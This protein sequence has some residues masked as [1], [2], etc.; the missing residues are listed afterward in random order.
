MYIH[1]I[2]FFTGN[3]IPLKYGFGVRHMQALLIFGCLT[4]NLIARAHLSVTIVAMTDI[5]I[6]NNVTVFNNSDIDVNNTAHEPRN[7]IYTYTNDSVRQ[8]VTIDITN[9]TTDAREEI[10]LEIKVNGTEI[11]S[12]KFN[13]NENKSSSANIDEF[14]QELANNTKSSDS[15]WNIYRVRLTLTFYFVFYQNL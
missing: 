14:E 10:N 12:S 2:Y 13:A 15:V 8:N 1:S 7:D 3:E 4:C 5:P 6:H 9:R 11:L